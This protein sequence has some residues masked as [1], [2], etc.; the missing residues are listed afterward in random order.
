MASSSSGV[1][2]NPPSQDKGKGKAKFEFILGSKPSSASD[3]EE[4]LGDEDLEPFPSFPETK[5]RKKFPPRR[6]TPSLP[7][8]PQAIKRPA[9]PLSLSPPQ[10]DL[11]TVWQLPVVFLL[12]A[13]RTFAPAT[14]DMRPFSEAAKALWHLK[15]A[16]D[17]TFTRLLR[18]LP[19]HDSGADNLHETACLNCQSGGKTC[20]SML[21]PRHACLSC[22]LQ[23][24]H[25]CG[26]LVKKEGGG[27]AVGIV[28]M[29]ECERIGAR[30][31][32]ARY[33][34]REV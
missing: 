27:L 19:A 20:L 15:L 18:E 12:G 21:D 31:G 32:D 2:P 9:T 22:S 17:G 29:P 30:R 5:T 16:K 13:S 33:W 3:D 28:P 11:Q 6:D 24:R 34:M 4:Y 14:D 7:T 8:R 1:N 25:M 26:R 10:R 23:K